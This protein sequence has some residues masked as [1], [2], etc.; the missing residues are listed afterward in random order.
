MKGIH[1]LLL[2]RCSPTRPVGTDMTHRSTSIA[3]TEDALEREHKR[4]RREGNSV[5]A[6]AVGLFT[7]SQLTALHDGIWGLIYSYAGPYEQGA[8]RS[9]CR[10]GVTA[11]NFAVRNEHYIAMAGS[12]LPTA[13]PADPDAQ[14]FPVL[15]SWRHHNVS[16]G[17]LVVS[18]R[19]LA[20]RKYTL[21]YDIQYDYKVSDTEKDDNWDDDEDAEDDEDE[22]AEGAVVDQYVPRLIK[23]QHIPCATVH[24]YPRSDMQTHCIPR[25]NAV[26]VVVHDDAS[27]AVP[28]LSAL[29]RKITIEGLHAVP[30][31]ARN[32][33]QLA[34]LSEQI[35]ARMPNEYFTLETYPQQ[36]GSP[37][38]ECHCAASC[39][40]LFQVLKTRVH[41][42][43]FNIFLW[44]CEAKI[45]LLA[46]L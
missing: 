21:N 17:T 40:E 46:T 5:A 34:D 8:L 14:W 27:C 41:N 11:F 39:E 13:D 23:V 42:R 43:N 9:T 31:G 16:T 7:V 2:L 33:G 36:E 24:W 38:G 18:E 4:H 29:R 10:R 32:I 35:A 30:L 26:C 28:T 3:T 15:P 37:A 25:T 12:A 6:G 20:P 1:S 22:T 44:T 19:V 45:L